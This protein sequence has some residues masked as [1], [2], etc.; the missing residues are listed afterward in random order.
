MRKLNDQEG[1]GITHQYKVEM[2]LVLFSSVSDKFPFHLS[3]Y[4]QD[5]CVI[6]NIVM[7]V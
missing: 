2:D 6:S 5:K 1:S 7:R 4:C 3:G